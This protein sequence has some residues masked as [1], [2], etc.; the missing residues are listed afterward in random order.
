[1]LYPILGAMMWHVQYREDAVH[2]IVQHPSPEQAIEAACR[3]IDDGCCVYGIGTGPLTDSI[4]TTEIAGI[5][6]LWARERHPLGSALAELP[7]TVPRQE[8]GNSPSD[9]KAA[10]KNPSLSAGPGRASLNA[11]RQHRRAIRR[12]T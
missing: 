7:P 5:Y 4:G 3:L 6:A 12:M 8:C 11:N 9:A 2:H 1:M 10:A